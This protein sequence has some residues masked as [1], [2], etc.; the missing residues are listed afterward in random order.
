MMYVELTPSTPSRYDGYMDAT[1]GT[2]LE[3]GASQSGESAVKP[4]PTWMSEQGRSL[5]SSTGE[6]S[7]E[8]E[9]VR[10]SASSEVMPH[11]REQLAK[12][13]RLTRENLIEI[14]QGVQN[15]SS[16]AEVAMDAE[17]VKVAAKILK[18]NIEHDQKNRGINQKV[19]DD[20]TKSG[21]LNKL[22][23]LEKAIFSRGPDGETVEQPSSHNRQVAILGK[24]RVVAE[25]A[26]AIANYYEKTQIS[27]EYEDPFRQ[28]V[29]FEELMTNFNITLADDRFKPGG[30]FS[31]LDVRDYVD[32]FGREMSEET[33]HP[34]NFLRWVT[35]RAEFYHDFDPMAPVKLF[36]GM[37]IVAGTRKI[38]MYE[39][40]VDFPAYFAHRI[41]T[42]GELKVLEADLDRAKQQGTFEY[43]LVRDESGREVPGLDEH[44][45]KVLGFYKNIEVIDRHTGKNKKIEKAYV[46]AISEQD[47]ARHEPVLSVYYIDEITHERVP[48][49]AHRSDKQ[50]WETIPPD[51]DKIPEFANAQEEIMYQIWLMGEN[52]NYD[53]NYRQK[54]MPS[55]DPLKE[56]LAEINAD[57][58]FT[59]TQRR[60]LGILNMP[61][62]T[63]RNEQLVP[64]LDE[65]RPFIDGKE[66]QKR[67]EQTNE[68]MWKVINVPNEAR[69]KFV[70]EYTDQ[71]T[72]GKAMQRSLAAYYHI[73]EAN[74][75]FNG[76]VI[77]DINP[78]FEVMKG[79]DVHGADIFYKQV[80]SRVLLSDKKFGYVH[81]GYDP[82][83][84]GKAPEKAEISVEFF[85]ALNDTR[86]PRGDMTY[87]DKDGHANVVDMSRTSR[88]RHDWEKATFV[89]F[90][91]LSQED[92][93]REMQKRHFT[94]GM[95]DKVFKELEEKYGKKNDQEKLA[96]LKKLRVDFGKSSEARR[97]D[98]AQSLVGKTGIKEKDLLPAEI[99]PKTGQKKGKDGI[100]YRFLNP[101]KGG[102]MKGL[103]FLAVGIFAK[104]YPSGSADYTSDLNPY[105]NIRYQ[106][107]AREL[108]RGAMRDA[109]SFTEKLDSFDAKWAEEW[110]F[111][112]TYHTGISAR[113][114]MGGI[115]HDAWSKMT[116]TEYYRL[117]QASGG[118]YP[119]NL[120]NLYGIH[121]LGTD[122][123]Q[124]LKVQ[125][126]GS[127]QFEKTIYEIITGLEKT[128]D[129]K[130]KFD[131]NKNVPKF[132]FAGNAQRQFF[133]DHVGH[134]IDLFSDITKKHEFNFD[135]IVKTDQMGRVTI[136]HTEMQKLIDSTWKHMRYGF[137]NNGF[138]YDNMMY[139]WWQ[140]E[141]LRANG[142]V[143]RT[144]HFG[145]KTLRDLM[146]SEEVQSMRM[147]ERQDVSSWSPT[148]EN[149][150]TKNGRNVFAYL[151]KAQFEE[152]TKRKGFATIYTA[153]QIA[154]ISQALVAYSARVMEGRPGEA[155]SLS[156]FFSPEEMTRILVF[157]HAI[158]WQL[159][160]KEYGL[161]TLGGFFAGLFQAMSL[162]MK[163]VG[164]GITLK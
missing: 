111:T 73:S 121:R 18:Y 83:K 60:L 85:N 16:V 153:D 66:N 41:P 9:A 29:S 119:G 46:S 2:P 64:V 28:I 162:I 39:M 155:V 140:D 95:F 131:I 58:K 107:N 26:E 100:F 122:W 14:A 43:T 10:N 84:P 32:E 47:Q 139:G 118:N 8:S 108:M 88:K 145:L 135:K 42:E 54:G 138:L 137:D 101:E 59:R 56:V 40:L 99:D 38:T 80:I 24:A 68:L 152:H 98:F 74:A 4:A 27:K 30:E 130:Y 160:A 3:Q 127:N 1:G 86:I 96:Q 82:E 51:A 65:K 150:A 76:Y 141:S 20:L 134:V 93:L 136:D 103:D 35:E 36:D 126:E 105:A 94:K 164:A 124:G 12:Q 115:G 62:T 147:Y 89:D 116:N 102:Q 44:K 33:A 11:I 71:G 142:Q 143:S 70:G 15:K 37:Y 144:N 72:L 31:L 5:I 146:F 79:N 133:A 149:L 48:V 78:F 45:D 110:A 21:V 75:A 91:T 67:D 113:N 90:M 97:K 148:P 19:Y 161:E 52:H 34:E 69:Q 120:D 22:D 151:I 25:L 13:K 55:E 81:D 50:Q 57:N 158:L 63:Y 154:L 23:E 114:D 128:P 104:A 49:M 129:G 61:A 6:T 87:T 92:F 7:T 109:L 157:A 163:E 106:L 159:Y 77:D 132:E 17:F 53:V 125:L 112:F 156:G 123:W 117:R